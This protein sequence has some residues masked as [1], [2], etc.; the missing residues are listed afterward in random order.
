MP[1]MRIVT[2]FFLISI[3]VT[4]NAQDSVG[5]YIGGE[6][7]SFSYDEDL[8]L[9]SPGT[10]LD[11]SSTSLKLF[12]GYRFSDYLGVEADWRTIDDL[13]ISESF[14]I[15]DVGTLTT[16][17]GAEVDALTIRVLGYAPLS[18][19]SFF[20]GGGYFDYDADVHLRARLQGGPLPGPGP[21]PGADFDL[22]DSTSDSGGTA[23]IGVQWEFDSLNIRF[24]YEWFNFEDADVEQIGIGLAYRF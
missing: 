13:E 20:Y 18:W 12:G 22:T 23:I 9:V 7:G 14:F 19:G 16:T 4:V 11:D 17:I 3:S 10:A 15:P 6:L 1:I 24:N 5:G 8:S 21:G 2:A